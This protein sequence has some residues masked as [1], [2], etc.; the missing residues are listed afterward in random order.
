MRGTD[1]PSC[2]ESFIFMTD[3]LVFQ[4]VRGWDGEW[5][6]SNSLLFCPTPVMYH[7]AHI[8][9]GILVEK[10]GPISWTA[11]LLSCAPL[12]VPSEILD[13]A[14]DLT[15]S[16]YTS[17]DRVKTDFISLVDYGASAL[18]ASFRSASPKKAV[19]EARVEASMVASRP[20][21]YLDAFK[22]EVMKGCLND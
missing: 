16:A 1:G 11:E 15:N 5:D 6:D 18:L 19:F 8:Y 20:A 4:T 17:E 10:S 9:L 21:V 12:S 13:A 2:P 14:F 3:T 7:E 22:M